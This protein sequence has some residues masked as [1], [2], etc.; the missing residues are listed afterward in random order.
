MIIYLFLQGSSHISLAI[1][2]PDLDFW[3]TECPSDYIFKQLKFVKLTDMCGV[4]HEMG[5]IRFLL[6]RSPM[7]ELM[8]I[9]PCIYAMESQLKMLIELVRFQRASAHAEISFVVD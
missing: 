1:E 6:A 5:F 7:L 8:A 4:P 2:A 3:S 9:A